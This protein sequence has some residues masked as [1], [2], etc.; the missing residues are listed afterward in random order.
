MI[1]EPVLFSSRICSFEY[2]DQIDQGMGGIPRELA[3][4]LIP[5]KEMVCVNA[6]KT[7]AYS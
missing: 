7:S 3:A 4:I 5:I 1:Q 6:V 2:R